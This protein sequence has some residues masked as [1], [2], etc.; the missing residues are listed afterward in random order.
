M[1]DNSAMMALF[2]QGCE[3]KGVGVD[4]QKHDFTSNWTGSIV[5]VYSW[6]QPSLFSI[7]A[8][9]W[10]TNTLQH[11]L[12]TL[13][14]T[15]HRTNNPITWKRGW[16]TGCNQPLGNLMT[17]IWHCLQCVFYYIFIPMNAYSHLFL[18][19]YHTV[20]ATLFRHSNKKACC[21]NRLDSGGTPPPPEKCPD[22]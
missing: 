5:I 11:A 16:V 18:V 17:S 21:Q 12:W 14:F 19:G 6:L 9:L 3:Q 7:Q 10:S 13:H 22:H 4:S 8:R 15:P 20:L 2:I 1:C